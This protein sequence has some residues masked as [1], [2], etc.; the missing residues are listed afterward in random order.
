MRKWYHFL[1]ILWLVLGIVNLL[2]VNVY[3]NHLGTEAD[4]VKVLNLAQQIGYLC[5]SA[6]LLLLCGV[7]L[8][9]VGVTDQPKGLV[10]VGLIVSILSVLFVGGVLVYGLAFDG[11][12][13]GTAVETLAEWFSFVSF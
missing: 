6:G 12:L 13:I 10:A 4:G 9:F 11:K 8:A 5:L 2:F 7:W 1:W 3:L